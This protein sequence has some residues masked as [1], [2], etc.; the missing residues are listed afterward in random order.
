[1]EFKEA[2]HLIAESFNRQSLVTVEYVT[3]DR[4]RKKG[5]ELKKFTGYKAGS[6]HS[7]KENGTITLVN[8]SNE[9]ATVHI[10]LIMKV[11]NQ[12]VF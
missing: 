3:F 10:P 7:S 6:S 11:N 8:S 4:A 1:M 12:R 5:G 9:R 2:L